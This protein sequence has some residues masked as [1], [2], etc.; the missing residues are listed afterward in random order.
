[1]ARPSKYDPAFC[2]EAF[3][4]LKQGYSATAFAGHIG[5]SRQTLYNWADERPEFFDALKSGQAAGVHWWEDRLRDIAEG[6][7]GNAT[8]AIFAL[9]NR[10]ADD[11]R[12]KQEVAHGVTDEFQQF[13]D[14]VS[15]RSSR[16]GVGQ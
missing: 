14:Q 2:D 3:E 1:M 10:G 5:V 8:A 12:D 11:W 6:K 4:F 7:D 16:I 13:L 15:A 9:K